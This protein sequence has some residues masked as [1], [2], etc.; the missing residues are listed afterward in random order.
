MD[1]EPTHGGNM[2]VGDLVKSRATRWMQEQTEFGIII[3][4]KGLSWQKDNRMWLVE[5]LDGTWGVLHESNLE[6]VCK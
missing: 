5:W 6:A 1:S 4:D 2:Q 3:A